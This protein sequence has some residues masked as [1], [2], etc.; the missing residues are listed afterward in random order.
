METRDRRSKGSSSGSQASVC[1]SSP[2]G[3]ASAPEVG[4]VQTYRPLPSCK[5]KFTYN[6]CSEPRVLPDYNPH[7]TPQR[8]SSISAQVPALWCRKA[9]LGT[10]HVHSTGGDSQEGQ[11]QADLPF[12]SW[13]AALIPSCNTSSEGNTRIALG[14]KDGVRTKTNLAQLKGSV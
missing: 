13:L 14:S 4:G 7:P 6:S 8:P 10:V 2:M 5:A 9:P 11:K 1:T 12:E 3:K